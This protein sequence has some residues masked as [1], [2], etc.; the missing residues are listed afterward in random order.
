M[1][2]VVVAWVLPT[3]RESGRPLAVDDIDR[4]E[5]EVSA[6]MGANFSPLGSYPIS[7]LSTEMTEIDPGEWM[8]RGR[9]FDKAQRPS[10]Y[11]TASVVVADTTPPSQL[12]L[13]LSVV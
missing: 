12:I 9:V 7:I 4:V 5:I 3:T 2:K 1:S 6:D 13:N 10:A 8:F 11:T